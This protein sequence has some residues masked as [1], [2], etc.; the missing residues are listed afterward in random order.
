MFNLETTIISVLHKELEYKV[1]KQST[2]TRS[3][4]SCSRGS[5]SN[6]KFQ[7]VNKR[8]RI[9]PHEVLIIRGSEGGLL[10]FFPSKAGGGGGL[11]DDLRYS[12]KIF[13]LIIAQV[14]L[15]RLLCC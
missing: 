13:F 3:W 8:F 15:P 10:T 7:L 6:A 11:I 5:E 4:K 1:E 9:R 14:D 2:A 12:F